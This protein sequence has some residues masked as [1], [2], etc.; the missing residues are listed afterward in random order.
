M[1]VYIISYSWERGKRIRNKDTDLL[2]YA[3]IE[4]RDQHEHEVY[5]NFEKAVKAA[6]ETLI[7]ISKLVDETFIDGWY[8]RDENGLYEEGFDY[9]NEEYFTRIIAFIYRVDTID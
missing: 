8:I 3:A 9:Y 2:E 4:E 7:E 5:T 6:K 1:K